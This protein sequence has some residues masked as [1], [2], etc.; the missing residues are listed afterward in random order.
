MVRR[1]EAHGVEP[2]FSAHLA[3]GRLAAAAAALAGDASPLADERRYGRLLHYAAENGHS[4]AT[5]WLLDHGAVAS[6]RITW[7]DNELTALHTAASHG[8]LD[9]V[10]SL[11]E[12]GADLSATDR[13]FDAV[14]LGWA[15]HFDQAEI[16]DFLGQLDA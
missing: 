14:P 9:A 10:R 8:H 15:R 5:A 13:C 2:D 4:A 11:V 6:G 3:A 12:G 7:W 1:L 16:A